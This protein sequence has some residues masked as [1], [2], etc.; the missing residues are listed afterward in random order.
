L[1]RQLTVGFNRRFAPFYI[2][3]KQALQ[4]RTS[5]R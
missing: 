1:G 2:E 5:R 3:L 4:K